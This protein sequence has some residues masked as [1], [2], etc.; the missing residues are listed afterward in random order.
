MGSDLQ[1][2]EQR[3]GMSIPD[4]YS[5]LAGTGALTWNGPERVDEH[6]FLTD[7]EWLTPA[8][9]ADYEFLLAYPGI[10]PFAISA[11]RDEW[12]W[13]PT[14]SEAGEPSV[15]LSERG[16]S[17][18]GY[19]PTFEAFLFR[20]LLEELAGTW[21]AD[22]PDFGPEG[23][24]RQIKGNLDLIRPVIRPPWYVVLKMKVGPSAVLRESEDGDWSL[25]TWEES[26][27]IVAAEL[28]W[29]HLDEEIEIHE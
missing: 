7:L 13:Y 10:V 29:S 8:E 23:A 12:A 18:T 28:Q 17:A 9:I 22:D 4:S 26:Q 27:S 25:I 16:M 21:L 19:A 1:R 15:V 24:L 14:W 3:F 5:D 6:L 11:R 20:R 2:A